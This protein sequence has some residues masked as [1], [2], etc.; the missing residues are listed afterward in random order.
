MRTALRIRGTLKTTCQE[1]LWGAS[2]GTPRETSRGNSKKTSEGAPDVPR[3]L[4]FL[5]KLQEGL[6]GYLLEDL[7]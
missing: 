1:T 6:L 5:V 2:G 3:N 4:E 7:L